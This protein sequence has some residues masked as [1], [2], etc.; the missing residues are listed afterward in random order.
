VPT[1][2]ESHGYTI[3]LYPRDHP[4]AHL[5]VKRGAGEALLLLRPL[6]VAAT[7][8][9]RP[10]E[11]K[12]ILALAAEREAALQ[13]AGDRGGSLATATGRPLHATLVACDGSRPSSLAFTP[14]ALA[15]ALVD[16]TVVTT[17]LDLHPW[18]AAATPRQRA[19]FR[20]AR[21]SV[22]WPELDEGLDLGWLG[23]LLVDFATRRW[24]RRFPT[25][26]LL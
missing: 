26:V 3:R 1:L 24:R 8:G 22:D 12:D 6:S 17:P 10:A 18:L 2:V 7:W 13:P 19:R 21:F 5:H 16:G 9:F 15:L 25:E 11:L 23:W 4:P 14:G 20:P